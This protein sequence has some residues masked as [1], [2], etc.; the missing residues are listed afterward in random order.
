MYQGNINKSSPLLKRIVGFIPA[1]FI[2]AGITI[3]VIYGWSYLRQTPFFLNYI[4]TP[5]YQP[6]TFDKDRLWEPTPQAGTKIGDLIFPSLNLNVRVVQGTDEDELTQGVGHYKDSALP[7]QNGNVYLA[8]HRDTVFVKLKDLKKG[9]QIHLSTPYGTFVYE[10]TG[11][12]I[13]SPTDTWVLKP[14]N[15]ETLTLQ[16]CYPFTY[17]GSAPDRYIVFTKFVS[18]TTH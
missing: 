2:L 14:T 7:G 15:Y 5:V 6:S 18:W 11:F 3:V 17:I 12:K 9:E 10:V 8:G 16:T 1:M 13:V 4:D